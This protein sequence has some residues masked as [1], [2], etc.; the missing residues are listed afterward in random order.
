MAG[1]AQ[2]GVTDIVARPIGKEEPKGNERPM[3]ERV[4]E[5]L[6]VHGLPFC[7][8]LR[9]E[10]TALLFLV[11]GGEVGKTSS[12]SEWSSTCCNLAGMKTKSS[13]ISPLVKV[14]RILVTN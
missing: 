7:L 6:Q 3:G 5:V 1:N 4:T 10:R 2:L 12:Y 14:L 11:H 13:I 9:L 8:P